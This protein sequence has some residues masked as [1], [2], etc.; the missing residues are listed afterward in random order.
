[1]SNSYVPGSWTVLAGP[2]LTLFTDAAPDT[3]WVTECWRLVAADASLDDLLGAIVHEGLRGVGAFALWSGDRVL[4]RGAVTVELVDSAGDRSPV[5]SPA[6]PTWH[7]LTIPAGTARLALLAAGRATDEPALPLRCGMALASA[8][9]IPRN[10]EATPAP[11]VV[12]PRAPQRSQAV[13]PG[14]A[15]MHYDDLFAMSRTPGTPPRAQSVAESTTRLENLA[16]VAPWPEK[17]PAPAHVQPSGTG[18]I[19]HLPWAPA[20]RGTPWVE[21][22]VP[23]KQPDLSATVQRPRRA[24]GGA[25]VS[26]VRC[27]TGHLNAVGADRCRVCG[28]AVVSQEPFQTTRPRLGLLVL[29]TDPE[30]IPLDRGVVFGRAP[31]GQGDVDRIALHRPDISAN[32]VEVRLSGW[33]VLVVDLGSTNGTLMATPDGHTSALVPRVPVE[34]QHGTE[35][36]LS[37]DIRFRFEATS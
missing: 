17:P 6:T 26:A 8:V 33:Q 5:E 30:P 31:T 21:A 37:E 22:S 11:V 19:E 20:G 24:G 34:I 7:E 2:E 18:V 3:A 4:V 13:E 1:M 16:P 35:I 14:E 25:V 27:A 9:H 28:D 15:S 29:S 36:L 10:T 23:E 12:E 32:H